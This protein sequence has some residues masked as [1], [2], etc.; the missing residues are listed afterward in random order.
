MTV[1]KPKPFKIFRAGTHTDSAGTVTT[2]T[3]E[4]LAASVQAYNDGE[5]R[6]PM[7][8]GHPKGDAP[9]YGWIGSLSLTDDGEIV[10]DTEKLNPEFAQLMEDGAYRNR[11]ASWYAPDHPSNPSPGVWQL[12]HL[13]MLGA[14]PPALKGLGDVQFH[15]QDGITLEFAAS[16]YTTSTIAR[17]LR[18]LRDSLIS[19]WGV[20]ETD[21]ALPS[22][23]IEDLEAAGREQIQSTVPNF[24]EPEHD[25]T[26]AEI[27][28]L[29]ARA[30]AGDTA[31]ATA[32]ALQAERDALATRVASFEEGER[33][34]GQAVARTAVL[35]ALAPFVTAGKILPAQLEA[36]ADFCMGLDDASKTVE[37]GEF[38]GDNKL[39]Q[40][41]FY[42]KQLEAL[43]AAVDYSEHTGG[44]GNGLPNSMTPTDIA[45]QARE[46][47]EA[48]AGKGVTISVTQAVD[49]VIAGKNK[50]A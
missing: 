19:K 45:N 9:A 29:E 42:L 1:K 10:A 30:T 48:Q 36:T 15:D 31:V 5:W 4:Q 32:T 16:D 49:A 11:S 20:E 24:S 22:W 28:A 26:P 46:Y 25:M 39:T 38:T 37:F 8:V 33:T 3:R 41:G 18:G 17:L 13:G 12:R 50:P 7:V 6:A 21:K 27:A 47:Q 34:R 40:R 14:Q 43:P 44:A 35:A 2:F 23:S